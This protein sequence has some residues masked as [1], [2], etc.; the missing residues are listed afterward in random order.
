VNNPG[1]RRRLQLFAH[2]FVGAMIGAIGHVA[3]MNFGSIGTPGG[4]GTTNGVFLVPIEGGSSAYTRQYR[5]KMRGL[6]TAWANDV[7]WVMN[8]S[9]NLTYVYPLLVSWEVSSTCNDSDSSVCVY[10][11]NYGNN[12]LSGWNACVGVAV[13]SHPNMTCTLNRV[14]FNTFAPPPFSRRQTACHELG[15]AWGLQHTAA[16][17]TCMNT[18]GIGGT[19]VPSNHDISHITCAYWPPGC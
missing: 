11:E 12:G 10:A 9:Y 7:A 14:R 3:A 5:V 8:T 2:I 1:R 13:G 15:H 6:P 17:D 4:S 16:T 18:F 19:E